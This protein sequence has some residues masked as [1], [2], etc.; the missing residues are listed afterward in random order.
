MSVLR[1]MEGATRPV[2]TLLGTM[3]AGARVAIYSTKMGE[4]VTV[5]TVL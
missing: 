4:A 5:S 2:S 3:N 1:I